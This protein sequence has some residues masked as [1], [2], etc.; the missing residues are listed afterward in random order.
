MKIETLTVDFTDEQKRYLEGFTT[1][2]RSAGSDAVLA[3]D[4]AGKANTEPTGPE[5]A[6]SRRRTRSPPRQEL[7]DQEN[8]SARSIH[9]MPIRG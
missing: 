5:A 9:S 7:A 6:I 4:S 2:C 1:D 3:A 8:S